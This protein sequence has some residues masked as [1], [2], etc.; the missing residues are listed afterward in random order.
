M[1]IVIAFLTVT[2]Y[3][4]TFTLSCQVFYEK[5]LFLVDFS[6]DIPRKQRKRKRGRGRF[7]DFYHPFCFF[8]FFLKV[9]KARRFILLA[10]LESLILMPRFSRRVYSL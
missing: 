5:K 3:C 9:K 4:T 7:L 8:F 2:P 6:I 1:G 10:K